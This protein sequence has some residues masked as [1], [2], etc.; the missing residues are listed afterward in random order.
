MT[1]VFEKIL[2]EG[3]RLGQAPN[4]LKS[5]T[6][7]RNRAQEV[8][9]VEPPVMVKEQKRFVNKPSLGHMILFQ[10]DPLLK[11]DLPYWDAFPLVFPFYEDAT[12]FTGINL[13][14][15]PPKMR[16]K[17][18]DALHNIANNQ[19][20]DHTTKL[21]MTYQLLN[22]STQFK[23][24]KPCV[25]QYLKSHVRSRMIRIHANE[26]NIALFLPIA[27]FKKARQTTVFNDTRAKVRK[28]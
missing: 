11:E 3:M 12:S 19:K 16:A 28:L 23:M 6:W 20:Y 13:H 1:T 8:N 9:R 27:R 18:M 17:L 25:R 4:E 2:Q 10:Y 21:R 5:R 22:S 24:F 14:Y 26:W 15:L 7:F